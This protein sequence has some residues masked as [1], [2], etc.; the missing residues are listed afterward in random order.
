MMSKEGRQLPG[1]SLRL[2]WTHSQSS[3]LDI[4]HRQEV[5]RTMPLR[6]RCRTML[7]PRAFLQETPT[8][9]KWFSHIMAVAILDRLE[10]GTV[11]MLPAVDSVS[12]PSR[13]SPMAMK[14]P[15][16]PWLTAWVRTGYP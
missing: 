9:C 2:S 10:T 16:G 4:T 5:I 6:G 13:L 7:D 3:S 15:I 11:E 8:R 1:D 14:L 12:E